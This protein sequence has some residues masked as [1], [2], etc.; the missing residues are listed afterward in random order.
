MANT[1]N[2]QPQL[3]RDQ[4][5]KLMTQK[6]D[7]DIAQEALSPAQLANS[8]QAGG[9]ALPFIAGAGAVG[10]GGGYA[11]YK[12]NQMES[13]VLSSPYKIFFG[14]KGPLKFD[15]MGNIQRKKI[16]EYTITPRMKALAKRAS[17]SAPFGA[18]NTRLKQISNQVRKL[19]S[20]DVPDKV[21][22]HT[23]NSRKT[24]RGQGKNRVGNNKN[25]TRPVKKAPA[26][27]TRAEFGNA[28]SMKTSKG[29]SGVLGSEGKS[30]KPGSGFKKALASLI[31]LVPM[32]R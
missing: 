1:Q 14:D 17:M 11:L 5:K 23:P 9:S 8:N 18:T 4:I 12:R 26:R 24:S 16:G 13:K 29:L 19:L 22:I 25:K 20:G 32:A 31:D 7:G 28:P 3:S 27:K 2:Q 10:A 15:Q 21:T 6:Q 30:M